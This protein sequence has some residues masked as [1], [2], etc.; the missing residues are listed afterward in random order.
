LEPKKTTS[1]TPI[2]K[3]GSIMICPKCKKG[4]ILKGKAAYGCSNYKLG[5][6]FKVAFTTVRE[7]LADKKP[8]EELVHNI[9][10]QSI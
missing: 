10:K 2:K 8:T 3:S 5:C 6:D 7:K 1:T 9:L 4:T